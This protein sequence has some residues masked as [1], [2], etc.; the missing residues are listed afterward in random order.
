MTSAQNLFKS[1]QFQE[2]WERHCSFINLK[3]ENFME[4]QKR[5]LLEQ[6]ALL[7]NCEL[8]DIIMKGHKPQTIEEFRKMVPLTT[9]ADYQP[10]FTQKQTNILPENPVTWLHTS[11]RSGEYTK[12]VP[13]TKRRYHEMGML[14]FAALV[15][16]TCRDHGDINVAVNDRWF[17]ALA[18]PPYISGTW[19]RFI[20]QYYPLTFLPTLDE[21]EKMPFNE[22]IHKGTRLALAQGIDLIGGMPSVL[23]AVGN[24][25]SESSRKGNK[26]SLYKNP[27]VLF[28]MI[29]GILKSKIAHRKLLP[30]DLWKI[31]GILA[32]GAST[33]IYREKIK[34]MW[35]RYPL[36]MYT[37]T[38]GG[39]IAVQTWDYTGMTFFPSLNFL[40]FITEEDSK[41]LRKNP[42]YNPP[43]LLL[44]EVEP[45]KNYELVI[46]NFLGGS[47]VRYR[48]GDM[49]RITALRNDA[50][51][52]DIPQMVFYSRADDILDIA[53]F[54]RLTEKTIWHAIE[55]TSIPYKGW[56]A[57]IEGK[58]QIVLHVYVELETNHTSPDTVSDK[59]HQALYKLDTDYASLESLLGI[60]PIKVTILPPG[61][62]Q[63][64]TLMQE[65]VNSR[66]GKLKPPHINPT[67]NMLKILTNE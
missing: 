18:P 63:K 46:T 61:A 65:S 11:G 52:I 14:C 67:E 21:A 16:C 57:R 20:A 22:S 5:L 44:D 51:N 30:R 24:K 36:D 38:E 43:T 8:G 59:I 66:P 33:S 62:F 1:G 2:L 6:L 39:M 35:G 13:L 34:E 60:R 37:F 15:F 19:A 47:L 26:W 54:T 56:T 12:W 45:G 31:K 10:Y 17:Y 49:I 58:D 55:N 25:L 48:V 42:D 3:I 28:R 27:P 40:E 23:L 41:I 53:G 32:G 9:Y 29:Q 50:L 64:Y 4:I 7:K